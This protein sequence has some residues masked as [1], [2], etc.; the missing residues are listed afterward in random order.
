[1][2]KIIA[3]FS[4]LLLFAGCSVIMSTPTKEVEVFLGKYQ[5]QDNEVIKQLDSVIDKDTTMNNEQ[6]KEYKE[7]MKKQYQNLTYKIKEE[8]IDGDNATVE[9]EIEVFDFYK[10]SK[11]ADKELVNNN[12]DFLGEDGLVD[13]SKFMDYKI[14][15]LKETKE[16][17]TYTL[18]FTLT[19]KDKEWVMND[20]TD[21]D[22]EKIHGIYNY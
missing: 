22:R 7:V 4:C 21:S 14:K 13:N 10:T 15:K 8:T 11:D 18:N 5:K 19:K 3:L 1:M 16:K 6:K 20:I 2:K 9:V 17:V 12:K